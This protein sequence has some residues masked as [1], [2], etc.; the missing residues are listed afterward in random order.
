MYFSIFTINKNI[1]S[2]LLLLCS[3]EI[4]TI[5]I[6]ININKIWCKVRIS[7]VSRTYFVF[8]LFRLEKKAERQPRSDKQETGKKKLPRERPIVW[9][10]IRSPR[11]I[12]SKQQY[13]MKGCCACC[14]HINSSTSCP[15]MSEIKKSKSA[16]GSCFGF[17][18]VFSRFSFGFRYAHII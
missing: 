16:R 2:S 15:L 8:F 14:H 18:S 9:W 7:H 6:A 4:S 10:N 12:L 11:V 13:T 3:P 1:W 17:L 5:T